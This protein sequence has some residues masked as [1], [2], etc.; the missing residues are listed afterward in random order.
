MKLYVANSI[1]FKYINEKLEAAKDDIDGNTVLD[2]LEHILV[3]WQINETK[4]E[5][6]YIKIYFNRYMSG[7]AL[8]PTG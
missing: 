5:Q 4:Y 1:A 3:L 8:W 6:E 7:P 2:R